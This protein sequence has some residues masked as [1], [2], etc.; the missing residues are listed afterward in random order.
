MRPK[1]AVHLAEA[2]KLLD[3]LRAG[4]RLPLMKIDAIG[5][6]LRDG[7]LSVIDIG[8]TREEMRYLW[9]NG[10]IATAHRFLDDMRAGCGSRE[11]S[12]VQLQECLRLGGLNL[13]D[14]GISREELES[15]THRL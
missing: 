2:K 5:V 7:H 3:E 1:R 11:F 12:I 6:H 15:L 10:C 9:R 14:I 4:T 13:I 8:T